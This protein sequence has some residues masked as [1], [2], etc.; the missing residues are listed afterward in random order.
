MSKKSIP[1]HLPKRLTISFPLWLI[2]GTKGEYS[3]YY[4]IEKVLREHAERGFNCIRIDSGAGLTHDQNG[5]RRPPFEIA[6]MFGEYER[7]PRQQKIVGDGGPCDLLARLIETLKVAKRYGIYVILSQWYYLHTYWFH[8]AGDPVCDELFA[9]TAEQRIPAFAKFWHYI[10]CEI[11]QEG[12]TDRIVFVELFN[13]A[14]EHP[15]LCG[16]RRWGS[17]K[18][19]TDEERAAFRTQHEQALTWLKSEHPSL[20][21]AYDVATAVPQDP[22]FPESAD[23]YNFHSYYLWSLYAKT[24]ADHPEWR[25][26]KVTEDDVR[27]ARKDRLPAADD[28]YQRVAEY[29]D[30]RPEALPEIEAALEAR[31]QQDKDYYIQ[32]LNQKL[33]NA[34]IVAKDRPIVCGEGVSYICHK[35]I[36]WEEHSAN[37]WALVKHGLSLYKKAGVWGSVIRTCCAPEDP[38]WSSHPEKLRELN[39][40]FLEG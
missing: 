15:Y 30:L 11:E 23:A 37:Y 34:C 22:S 17:N 9:L 24:L 19:L 35:E 14:D 25:M 4:D 33:Q 21:F 10:L 27:A 31:L 40:Y 13:E 36:L 20:L 3:P 2:Y 8:K 39:E 1:S 6:D 5:N 18:E 32:K 38:V 7:V 29:N 12:L 16:L 26:G 28:W